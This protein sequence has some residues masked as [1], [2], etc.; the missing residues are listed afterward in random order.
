MQNVYAEY[1]SKKNS[2]D[3][4]QE[5]Y[6]IAYS[7]ELLLTDKSL[8]VTVRKEVAKQ[9]LVDKRK[10]V[11]KAKNEVRIAEVN[12]RM[13]EECSGSVRKLA[14]IRNNMQFSEGDGFSSRSQGN[15]SM[16]QQ[17]N[18]AASNNTYQNNNNFQQPQNNNHQPPPQNN[19][20]NNQQPP[21]NGF[22]APTSFQ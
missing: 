7:Q 19:H 1:I 20:G 9:E 17:N 5:E 13:I 12:V 2:A 11:T 22:G 6:D 10:A 21:D 18:P 14:N 3:I 4:A 15:N 16:S 8:N